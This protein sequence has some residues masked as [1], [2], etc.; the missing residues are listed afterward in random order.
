MAAAFDRRH[1][2][3]CDRTRSSKLGVEAK[4]FMD[5][6]SLVPDDVVIGLIAERSKAADCKTGLFWTDFLARFHKLKLWMRCLQSRVVKWIALFLFNIPD[7]ELGQPTF[8]TP[9]L[10]ELRLDV[11]HRIDETQKRRDL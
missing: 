11:P 8:R 4:S 2:E 5:K 9:N 6:G 10:F 3:D 7:A 1:V